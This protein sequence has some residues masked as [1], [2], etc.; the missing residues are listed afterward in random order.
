[1]TLC[2]C[3]NPQTF[4]EESVNLNVCNIFKKYTYLEDLRTQ[5]KLS[6]KY[7]T[8]LQIN[9]D[10]NKFGNCSESIRLK[11]KWNVHS[12]VVL[13]TKLFIINVQVKIMK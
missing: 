11:A 3:Q 8:L 12:T 2:T 13:L 10:L 9:N 4:T 7:L 5:R 1:M 6:Q